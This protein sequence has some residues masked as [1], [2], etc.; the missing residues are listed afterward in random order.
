MKKQTKMRRT[1]VLCLVLLTWAV[2]SRGQG[3]AGDLKAVLQQTFNQFDSASDFRQKLL[4][5]GRLSM[6]ETKWG[7]EWIA[8]YYVAYGNAIL[9][10]LEKEDDKRDL[11]LDA[12]DKE[13]DI[14]VK[15][16]G[17]EN[18]ETH[19]LAALIANWRIAISPMNRGMQY[20]KVFREHMNAAQ[21]INPRNPR[22]YYL[23][24]MA[25]YS[26]PK[27]VGGGKDV[28][29]PLLAKAD[30]LYAAETDR[31]I[32]RPYWGK[33]SNGYYLNLCRKASD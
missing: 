5:A 25:K 10:S 30:S 33:Q 14:A 24:G 12:A 17:Q 18:D 32:M 22:I 2:A 26:M 13:R 7:N 8:H 3:N 6:I 9:S 4:L 1:M 20:G 11:Y 16:L 23:E 21:S 19:V 31:D 29:M 15:L 27:F 28:A